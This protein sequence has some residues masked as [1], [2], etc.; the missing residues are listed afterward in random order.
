MNNTIRLIISIL[1]CQ[2]AGAIGSIFTVSSV[3]TWYVTLIKPSFNPPSWIFGPVWTILYTL[4]GISL[5]IIWKQKLE[6]KN[7]KIALTVFF[8]QLILNASWSFFFFGIKNLD[9]AFLVIILMW[10]FIA[11]TIYFFYR[12]SS[13]AGLLQIPYLLWVSF[14]SILNYSIS[15]LN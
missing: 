4:M 2:S 5:W 8:I 12:I 10:I 6:G 14:A 11:A 9:V 7:V 3:K 13:L 15:K 1:I